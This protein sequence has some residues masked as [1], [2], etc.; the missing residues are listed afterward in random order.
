MPH[1]VDRLG[2]KLGAIVDCYMVGDSLM[3]QPAL[4]HGVAHDPVLNGRVAPRMRGT[5]AHTTA[6]AREREECKGLAV[7]AVPQ[8]RVRAPRLRNARIK[9]RARRRMAG[10]CTPHRADTQ[11]PTHLRPVGVTPRQCSARSTYVTGTAGAAPGQ[12][13]RVRP[14]YSPRAHAPCHAPQQPTR[15]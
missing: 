13:S 9:A 10:W 12:Q 15:G 5:M 4:V 6:F 3:A 8:R 2:L 1:G 14:N 11:T 7:L